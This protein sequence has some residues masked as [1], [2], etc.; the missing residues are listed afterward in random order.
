MS[1]QKQLVDVFE[2]IKDRYP[3]AIIE[4]NFVPKQD[5]LVEDNDDSDVFLIREGKVAVIIGGGN[6][7]VVLGKDDLIGEMSFLLGNKRT[8]SIVAKEDVQCWSVNVHSMEKIFDTDAPLATKF[9]KSLGSLIANRLVNDSKR[10]TQ[11]LVFQDNDDALLSL[12]NIQGLEL[13]QSLENT[14]RIVSNRLQQM[15]DDAQ[16]QILDVHKKYEQVKLEHARSK[17]QLEIQRV[18]D[19]LTAD[20]EVLF[21]EIRGRLL[22][23]FMQIQ[24]LLMEILDLE[25]RNEVGRSIHNIFQK[26]VFQLVPIVHKR[27]NISSKQHQIEPLLLSA[28]LLQEKHE[29]TEIWDPQMV[30]A[31]WID[32]ILKEFPTIK[33]YQKRHHLISEHIVKHV[34]EDSTQ[35]QELRNATAT[36]Y[37]LTLVNDAVGSI[38][39]RIYAK[40]A[41]VPT[42]IHAVSHDA[43]SLYYMDSGM[44]VRSGKVKMLFH[45]LPSMASMLFSDIELLPANIPK[46]SQR[47]IAVDGVMDYLPDRYLVMLIEKCLPFLAEGGCILLSSILPTDDVAFITDFLQWP[48]VRRTEEELG[49]IFAIFSMNSQTY[50]QD[51]AIVIK[52]FG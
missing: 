14:S 32:M 9:Y 26:S 24:H 35:M 25:K 23:I 22:S 50:V 38:L 12:M 48:M 2:L 39:A 33:A 40:V 43:T 31:H 47:I 3:W 51:N 45:K 17:K 49:K 44:D 41:R 5:I 15:M 16:R 13:R 42:E 19:E 30:I 29:F 4:H 27:Q 8:A 34:V 7:E 37:Q 36:R 52:L 18:I 28:H 6:S 10:Y 46:K 20:Q 21:C 1:I 11:N